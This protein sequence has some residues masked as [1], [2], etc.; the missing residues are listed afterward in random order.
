MLEIDSHNLSTTGCVC[1][2]TLHRSYWYQSF[3]STLEFNYHTTDLLN[4][5]T[6]EPNH[7]GALL[8]PF[9]ATIH[10]EIEGRKT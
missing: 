6:I 4:I 10:V 3:F 9:S 8:A 1:R 5:T 2:F 7:L